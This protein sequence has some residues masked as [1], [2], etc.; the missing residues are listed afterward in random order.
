MKR[1][2]GGATVKKG[3]YLNTKT[4][5]FFSLDAEKNTLPGDKTARFARVPLAFVLIAG[6]IVGLAYIIFI[7][8][9]GLV[10]LFVLAG[11]KVKNWTVALA[12]RG[13][14]S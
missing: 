7:P 3:A 10:S 2:E 4:G 1:F 14:E 8:L 13:S 6:P 12:H 9:A 11:H 5:E